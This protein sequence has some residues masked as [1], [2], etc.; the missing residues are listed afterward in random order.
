MT[1]LVA[2]STSA[3]CLN[4]GCVLL[5]DHKLHGWVPPGGEVEPGETPQQALVREL[6]EE[7]G[8][9]LRRDYEFRTSA[10]R[11]S[12]PGFF[13]YDEHDAGP[14]GLHCNFAF[15]VRANTRTIRACSEYRDH[16]W[17]AAED[18]ERMVVRL[19]LN[20]FN[21]ARRALERSDQP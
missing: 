3:Y 6:R 13:A 15:L 8:W 5:I 10:D 19:R 7:L 18:V 4:G 16:D 17:F 20:V 21:L 12:P 2:F 14:K 9:E 1:D 11:V